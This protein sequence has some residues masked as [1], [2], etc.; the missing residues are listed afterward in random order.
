M[1]EFEY[2]V[3]QL[4][5]AGIKSSS[6]RLAYEEKVKALKEVPPQL[7]S[8]GLSEEQIAQKMH[9]LRRELGR[10]YKEAAP[11]LFRAY[12]LAATAAKYG[13]PLGPTYEML[14]E[15]K[16][17]GQIIESATR[18]IDDLDDRLT[19]EGFQAWYKQHEKDL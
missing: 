5:K 3:E 2:E 4:I 18:P 19:L 12:I 17:C 8:K 9:T 13:D 1:S 11:P 14:R 10:Q 15:K 7:R 6:L 16:T